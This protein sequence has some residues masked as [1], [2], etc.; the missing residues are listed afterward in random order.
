M[1]ERRKERPELP[2]VLDRLLD[3]DP[4]SQVEK[5]ISIG[6]L[7]DSLKGA[8]RRDLEDLLNA[9]HRPIALPEG[10]EELE[11]STFEYGIADFTGA[12]LSSTERRR[13]Y[14]HGIEEAIR[15]HETR[16]SSLRV[17]QADERPSAHRT[18]HFRIEA[19]VRTE[20]APESVLYDSHVDIP[21]R[22]FRI[23]V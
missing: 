21:S 9:R 22:S 7:A 16:F 2:S 6:E 4:G 15:R 1:A 12:N 20:P 14:L 23:Q 17:V 18:L 11:R 3:G 5:P 10:L 8:I 19:V 13:K